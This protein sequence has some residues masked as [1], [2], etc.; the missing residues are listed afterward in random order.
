MGLLMGRLGGPLW[1][2][3]E[4]SPGIL[5]LEASW[6]AEPRVAMRRRLN[7]GILEFVEI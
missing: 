6:Q 1:G 5:K 3:S 2:F 7:F 4:D